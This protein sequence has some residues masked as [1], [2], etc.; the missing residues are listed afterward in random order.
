[1]ARVNDQNH[2]FFVKAF[3][4]GLYVGQF[5]DSV[6]LRRPSDMEEIR[7][8]TEKHIEVGEDLANHLEAERQ[9]ST[10]Q[11]KDNHGILVRSHPR[12]GGYK[13]HSKSN[14]EPTQFTPLK[15]KKPKAKK[16]RERSR[17]RHHLNTSYRGT[18]TTISGSDTL[19]GGTASARKRH[20]RAIMV[21][22]GNTHRSRDL[23]ICFSNEDYEGTPAHQNDPMRRQS[24]RSSRHVTGYECRT[25]NLSGPMSTQSKKRLLDRL[26]K[27]QR[28]K[29][30]PRVEK[31]R[32][33]SLA[34]EA[35]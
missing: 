19:G 29:L 9:S 7:A 15:A 2:K 28:P 16:P 31:S 33:G 30:G 26:A 18:I 32:I 13:I 14:D 23:V 25:L 12:V 5:S 8:W 35:N 1:M 22:Q 34:E 3:Q 27:L 11:A 10:P 4:K 20:T 21:V 6:V 17:S 24:S